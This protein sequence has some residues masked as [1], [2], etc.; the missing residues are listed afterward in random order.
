MV[1][2][3]ILFYLCKERVGR[4][5]GLGNWKIADG[6]LSSLSVVEFYIHAVVENNLNAIELRLHFYFWQHPHWRQNVKSLEEKQHGKT[7]TILNA[8]QG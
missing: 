8:A 1:N 2:V 3:R 6:K 5:L 4:E 7:L